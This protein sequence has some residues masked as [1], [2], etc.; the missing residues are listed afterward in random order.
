[1]TASA[2]QVL[3]EIDKLDKIGI[4][5]VCAMLGDGKYDASGAFNRGAGLDKIQ[6]AMIRFFLENTKA[7]GGNE[8][9][10]KATEKA[11]SHLST[12]RRRIDLIVIMEE[13]IVDKKNRPNRMGCVAGN[14][15][16][17]R[18]IVG[19]QRQAGECRMGA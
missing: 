4:D 16:Q 8:G 14:A 15:S 12:V 7:Q 11:L 2:I 6:V 3:R 17:C 1:M 10:L 18:R 9:T 5:G 19:W 13:H